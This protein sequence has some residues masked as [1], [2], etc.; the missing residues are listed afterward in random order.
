MPSPARDPRGPSSFWEWGMAVF[1]AQVPQ[2]P[3][4]YFWRCFLSLQAHVNSNMKNIFQLL[5]FLGRQSLRPAQDLL[6]PSHPNNTPAAYSWPQ[7]F[8]PSPQVP[9]NF[10]A[11]KM[12]GL[13]LSS[14]QICIYWLEC[15]KSGAC[16]ITACS[17]GRKSRCGEG[18]RW[19]SSD[20]PLLTVASSPSWNT[21]LWK[22]FFNPTPGNWFSSGKMLLFISIAFSCLFIPSLPSPA[23]A[24]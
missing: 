22:S 10:K 5:L 24:K 20:K 16:K 2:Y 15:L 1:T 18:K 7:V 14:F 8:L 3:S 11:Q 21:W 4:F 9:L 13:N 23:A 6:P 19:A 17:S 12:K